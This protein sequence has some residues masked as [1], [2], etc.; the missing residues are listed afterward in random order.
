MFSQLKTMSYDEILKQ[1]QRLTKEKAQP[2]FSEIIGQTID[3]GKLAEFI[4]ETE[5]NL[6]T[7]LEEPTVKD[8]YLKNRLSDM[9]AELKNQTDRQK[10]WLTLIGLL[11]RKMIQVRLY[12]HI[13]V[14]YSTQIQKSGQNKFNYIL[15]RA[16]FMD[17]YTGKKEIR[18]YYKKLEDFPNFTSIDKLKE[19]I[20]FKSSAIESVRQEMMN[21]MEN[22]GIDIHYIREELNKMRIENENSSM[23]KIVEL[24]K[25]NLQLRKELKMCR[26]NK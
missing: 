18:I 4:K 20:H 1:S 16:P 6:N 22:D 13:Q 8:S 15:L 9:L 24:T 3:M 12:R 11:E 5:A 25:I 21:I 17:V 2:V 19:D 14:S 23:R 26:E 7:E 10:K